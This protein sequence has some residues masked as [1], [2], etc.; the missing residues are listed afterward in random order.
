M[1]NVP[2]PP[3]YFAIF[4]GHGPSSPAPGQPNSGPIASTYAAVYLH[5]HLGSLL[6]EGATVDNALRGA[7]AETD[8]G[9]RRYR[10]REQPQAEPGCTALVLLRMPPQGQGG[11][12]TY[13]LAHA[14]DSPCFIATATGKL[15]LLTK[16]HNATD[17]GEVARVEKLGGKFF[18]PPNAP[19]AKDREGPLERLQGYLA[20]SRGLGDFAQ[21]PY[22][23]WE[24]S[25][26]SFSRSTL[27]PAPEGEQWKFILL[28]SDGVSDFLPPD[29]LGPV[30]ARGY[31]KGGDG[32]YYSGAEAAARDI[33]REAV[34][35]GGYDNASCTV[36][37]L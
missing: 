36:V 35:K 16:P 27:P 5:H 26:Q 2:V 28:C 15:H 34:R 19:P 20:C 6:N 32:Y 29:Q 21:R 9:L 24:P 37:E 14:G 33:V 23:T 25:I 11:E 18:A 17:P 13:Y 12:A 8:A 31:Q 4:D 22:A 7:F 10:D 3:S 1:E 30:L